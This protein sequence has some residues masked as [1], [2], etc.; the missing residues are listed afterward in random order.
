MGRTS[1]EERTRPHP[2][3]ASAGE[4]MFYTAP[5]TVSPMLP[6]FLKMTYV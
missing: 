1:E 5:R 6:I 3:K 2:N 4:D